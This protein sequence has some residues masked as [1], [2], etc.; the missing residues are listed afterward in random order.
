MKLITRSD[1]A[2]RSLEDLH[3]LY[4]EAFNAIA[5]APRGSQERR[6]ALASLDVIER[7]LAS[8]GPGF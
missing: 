3:G 5:A 1:A 7:E 2:K 8:R 4:R 6:N